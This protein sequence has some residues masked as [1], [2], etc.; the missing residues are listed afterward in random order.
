MPHNYFFN[1]KKKEKKTID[2]HTQRCGSTIKNEEVGESEFTLN[3]DR[4]R[5]IG[6]QAPEMA[7][8]DQEMQ[9]KI[10]QALSIS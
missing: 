9:M 7:I 6:V 2:T 10:S 3:S 8:S 4:E 1:G 5:A